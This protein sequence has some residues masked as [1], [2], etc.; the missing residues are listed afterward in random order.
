MELISNSKKGTLIGSA[1]NAKKKNQRRIAQI[2]Y[3]LFVENKI[4]NN[5][6]TTLKGKEV[7]VPGKWKNQKMETLTAVNFNYEKI[8]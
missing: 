8:F 5:T 6:A 4:R 2:I 7:Q 1:F 3:S